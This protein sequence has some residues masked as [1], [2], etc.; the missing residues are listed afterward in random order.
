[1]AAIGSKL[2]MPK[3]SF[4]DIYP[5][6][7]I[8]IVTDS[9]NAAEAA[10]IMVKIP[11]YYVKVTVDDTYETWM[12]SRYK[13]A[14]YRVAK[15]FARPDGTEADYYEYARY[16]T[17][18]T[19]RSQTG[20]TPQSSTTIE[21][22]RTAAL[23]LGDN[24][25]PAGLADRTDGLQMLMTIEFATRNIQSIAEG[26]VNSKT[27]SDCGLTDGLT[28]TE[29]SKGIKPYSGIVK[30]A[31]S[32]RGIENPYGNLLEYAD[33]IILNN[34]RVYYCDDWT[35]WSNSI[36]SSY[37]Q[38][39]GTIPTSSGFI[40]KLN[41]NEANPWMRLPSE[42]VAAGDSDSN[43]G[44]YYNAPTADYTLPVYGGGYSTNLRAGLFH[45]NCTR[46]F[47]ETNR[48]IGS[49]LARSF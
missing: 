40:T 20:V 49:R 13:K 23:G 21:A 38:A 8:R 18:D 4:D 31:F 24:W 35:R 5:W 9:D 14:G 25:H 3:N 6:S 7:D 19:N 44:D 2:V 28:I 34:S 41:Y 22:F 48:D 17:S 46:T 47:S 29:D 39:V 45:W 33:G 32:Y 1:M 26:L 12:I 16:E 27:V 30:N 10:Q 43:Y 42:V 37:V 11:K 15:M 36:N